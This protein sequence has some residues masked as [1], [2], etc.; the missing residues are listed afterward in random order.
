VQ[1]AKTVS[2]AGCVRQGFIPRLQ[3][4]D[5]SQPVVISAGAA[6]KAAGLR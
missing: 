4:M 1:G 3:T 2:L 5:W 6:D